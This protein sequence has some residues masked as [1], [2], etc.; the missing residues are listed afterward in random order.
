M[1]K[2][3]DFENQVGVVSV[4]GGDAVTKTSGALDT[5]GM[6]QAVVILATGT[7]IAT[8]TL[9]VKIEHS[10]DDSVWADLTGAVFPELLAANDDEIHYGIIKCN[11]VGVDR[12]LRISS[13]AAVAVAEHGALLISK[14]LSGHIPTVTNALPTPTFDILPPTGA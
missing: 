4:S 8:A 2:Y 7:M 11:Q 1:A 6:E 9:N 3:N 12:Y 14:N 5:K 13:T 10:P